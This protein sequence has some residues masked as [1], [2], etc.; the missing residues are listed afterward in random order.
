MNETL[1]QTEGFCDGISFRNTSNKIERYSKKCNCKFTYNQIDQ[2]E[3]LFSMAFLKF[4][5]DVAYNMRKAIFDSYQ[6]TE[7]K[8]IWAY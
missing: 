5:I 6:L 8:E 1:D 3:V 7:L 2:H 4:N